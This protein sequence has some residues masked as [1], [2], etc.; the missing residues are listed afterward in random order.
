[1][2]WHQVNPALFQELLV[3]LTTLK[4]PT[5]AN[6]QSLIDRFLETAATLLDVAVLV[7][8][9]RLCVLTAHAVVIEQSLIAA[10]DRRLPVDGGTL[11]V[12]SGS[13]PFCQP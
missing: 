10:S 7:R 8:L 4:V 9:S 6:H 5:A 1:M 11:L 2:G 13:T 3:R 12:E